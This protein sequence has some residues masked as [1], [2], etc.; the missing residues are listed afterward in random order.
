VSK[1]I[2]VILI[3]IILIILGLF[4][5]IH[6][7]RAI[8]KLV[9]PLNPPIA[10]E[11]A[12]VK[13]GLLETQ[14]ETIALIKS[15]TKA[16]V[17]AQGSGTIIK[18]NFYEGDRVNKGDIMAKIDPSLYDDTVDSAKAKF[19]AADKDYLKQK[20][21]SERDKIL[22]ENGA[23]SKQAYEIS[24]A[25]LES[26]NANKTSTEKALESAKTFRSYADVRAPYSGVVT[27]RLVHQGTLSR[28]LPS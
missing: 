10:V 12:K 25:Q 28:H 21:I 8:E 14:I 11:T 24:E 26:A 16:T 1:K 13:Y 5:V 9:P 17:S 22:Y 2:V 6:K 7:K 23:I 27:G 20:A 3:V 18:V 4:T 15:D 19:E